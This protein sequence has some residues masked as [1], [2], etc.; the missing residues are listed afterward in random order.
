MI[1][2]SPKNQA[3]SMY[4]KHETVFGRGKNGIS[5]EGRKNFGIWGILRF[6]PSPGDGGGGGWVRTKTVFH[7]IGNEKNGISTLCVLAGWGHV[8]L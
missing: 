6:G 7:L 1:H 2:F 3:D 8:N 5:A 4:I